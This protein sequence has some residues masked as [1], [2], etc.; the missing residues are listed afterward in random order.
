MLGEKNTTSSGR[1]TLTNV[2][3]PSGPSAAAIASF[4]R[5]TLALFSAIH[6]WNLVR[7]SSPGAS[8]AASRSPSAFTSASTSRTACCSAASISMPVS[9]NASNRSSILLTYAG[10]MFFPA[11]AMQSFSMVSPGSL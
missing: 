2:I 4:W 7:L 6:R 10:G 5:W 11:L 9:A 1:L 8:G 3:D